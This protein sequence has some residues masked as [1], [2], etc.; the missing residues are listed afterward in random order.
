MKNPRPVTG[1][2]GPSGPTQ[3]LE[4]AVADQKHADAQEGRLCVT[5]GGDSVVDTR[6]DISVS[7]ASRTGRTNEGQCGTSREEHF[8]TIHDYSNFASWQENPLRSANSR[9]GAG[10]VPGPLNSPDRARSSPNAQSPD[11]SRR[12]CSQTLSQ[13]DT[14][15]IVSTACP[16]F[17]A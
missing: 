2:G 4:E 9:G 12:F 17:S 3:T 8:V 16:I 1:G 13:R 10:D 15:L 5:P 11:L 6:A 7:R 14:W